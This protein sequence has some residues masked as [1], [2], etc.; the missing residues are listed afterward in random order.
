MC[1]RDRTYNCLF[2]FSK[3]F[4][5][6][7]FSFSSST[8]FFF[9]SILSLVLFTSS[10]SSFKSSF[11]TSLSALY[12][13]LEMY[14]TDFAFFWIMPAAMSTFKASYTL[15][16]MFFSSLAYALLGARTFC[17][18]L[19]PCPSSLISWSATSLYVVVLLSYTSSLTLTLRTFRPLEDL[20]GSRSLPFSEESSLSSRF[21]SEET[22][23]SEL[24]GSS[25]SLAGTDYGCQVW[26]GILRKQ[27][28]SVLDDDSG[29][30]CY[31]RRL[32]RA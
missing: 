5:D 28:R 10:S 13:G 1:I 20:T 31:L 19:L 27:Q 17:A 25:G 22:F 8:T 4:S 9:L 15:L 7:F 14:L 24:L 18:D 26:Y 6:R 16:L 29:I 3:Y 32:L 21:T 23:S 30:C 11:L 2:L 12:V